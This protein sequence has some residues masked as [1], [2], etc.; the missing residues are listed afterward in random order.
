DKAAPLLAPEVSG[1]LYQGDNRWHG[2]VGVVDTFT[3]RPRLALRESNDIDHYLWGWTD[4]PSN[5]LPAAGRLGGA[6]SIRPEIDSDGPRDLYVQSV[7]RAGN[8]SPKAVHHFYVRVGNGPLAQWSF[9]G[10]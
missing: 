1:V 6:A 9:E 4:P 5:V 8:K 10:N 7:D 2:G 3:F